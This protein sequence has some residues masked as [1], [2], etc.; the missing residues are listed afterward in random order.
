MVRQQPCTRASNADLAKIKF[1][2]GKF[3]VIKTAKTITIPKLVPSEM[4]TT[5][6]TALNESS[7]MSEPSSSGTNGNKNTHDNGGIKKFLTQYNVETTNSFE[8]LT[9]QNAQ[10]MDL[11]TQ[12]SGAKR[13]TVTNSQTLDRN[14]TKT[15][16]PPPIVLHSKVNHHGKFCKEI[17]NDI[18]KGYHIKYTK[19]NTNVFIHD[20][21]EFSQYLEQ[22]NE[23]NVEYH[24]YSTKYEKHHAFVIRGL[25]KSV[26]TSDVKLSLTEMLGE[27]IINVYQMKNTNG[28]FLIIT[29]SSL[30]VQYLNH[31]CRYVCHTRIFWE[32]Q[33][34]KKRITQCRRCQMW[35]HATTNCRANPKCVKCSKD[36]WSREC[37]LVKKEDASSSIFIKCANCSGPHLAMST[38]CPA[39]LSKLESIERQ[40]EMEGNSQRIIP[41]RTQFIPAPIPENAWKRNRTGKNQNVAP[42]STPTTSEQARRNTNK[43]DNVEMPDLGD[44]N[45]TSLVSEFNELNSLVDLN[46]MISLV[47]KLNSTLKNCKNDL[48]KFIT[49]N[50]FCKHNFGAENSSTTQC[51]P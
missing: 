42:P 18:K 32:R 1:K 33:Q 47:R 22:I 9:N 49:V 16:R 51:L 15:K 12:P 14:K 10:E 13:S 30:K 35:G 21:D 40:R 5:Q 50:N 45:F 36:H 20:H 7:V 44:N 39:Y 38:E 29:D 37:T 8:A 48:E 24:T 4:D 23:Q 27:K 28:L 25:D 2:P 43:Q 11:D 31:N 19:N 34:N 3:K 46:Y 41:R 17:D 6:L 26:E